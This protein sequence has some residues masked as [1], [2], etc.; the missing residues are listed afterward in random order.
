[1]NA[2]SYFFAATLLAAV[3]PIV[4]CA[5]HWRLR[6]KLSRRGT[7]LYFVCYG[8]FVTG[9]SFSVFAFAEKCG[10][11]RHF[12]ALL[13]LLPFSSASLPFLIFYALFCAAYS[14]NANPFKI[15]VSCGY[16]ERFF[17]RLGWRGASFPF[18]Y[19]EFYDGGNI[20][21]G[22]KMFSHRR[23]IR[24]FSA[25]SVLSVRVRRVTLQRAVVLHFSSGTPKCI[26]VF[27]M[28]NFDE[29]CRKLSQCGI[30]VSGK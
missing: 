5:T 15:G 14:A 17:D 7:L 29:I 3:F 30:P 25:D 12:D 18:G 27:P 21:I 2:S 1:M 19:I 9:Y 20:V 23:I 13:S 26:V 11:I 22:V 4:A 6:G 8:I 16:S 28:G 24:Q 10:Y